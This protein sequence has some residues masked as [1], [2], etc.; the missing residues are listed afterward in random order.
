MEVFKKNCNVKLDLCIVFFWSRCG[1]SFCY[2]VNSKYEYNDDV[3]KYNVQIFR[4]GLQKDC[5]VAKIP[6]SYTSLA[7]SLNWTSITS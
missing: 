3:T 4:L 7:V 1:F 5:C 2:C 6:S